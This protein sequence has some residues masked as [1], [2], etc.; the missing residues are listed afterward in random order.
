MNKISKL[1]CIGLALLSQSMCLVFG[2]SNIDEPQSEK[3]IEKS[4]MSPDK[5]REEE[6]LA[7]T[8]VGWYKEAYYIHGL[9]LDISENNGDYTAVFSFYPLS[10]S[11]K[12]ESG[13][14]SMK[15]EKNEDGTYNFIQNQWINQPDGC[16]MVDLLNCTVSNSTITGDVFVNSDSGSNKY[17]IGYLFATT[18]DENIYGAY[19][20]EFWDGEKS[21]NLI[22]TVEK[23]NGRPR[24]VLTSDTL[25]KPLEYDI[26]PVFAHGNY[27]FV[28]AETIRV[29]PRM[30]IVFDVRNCAVHGNTLTGIITTIVL[31]QEIMC[32]TLKMEKTK[33]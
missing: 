29:S 21:H 8:Y 31:G 11:A 27:N 13:S 30:Q 5:T 32:G 10:Y 3:N 15:V 1:F 6:S 33:I 20:S 4:V 22:L 19:G 2:A 7:G 12:Q 9:N 18:I 23:S 28:A 26:V 17:E 24:A 16:V 14:F 25:D